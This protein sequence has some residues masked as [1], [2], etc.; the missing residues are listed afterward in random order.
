MLLLNV[1]SDI[2]HYVSFWYLDL[3]LSEELIYLRSFETSLK[4]FVLSHTEFSICDSL[5]ELFDCSTD[6]SD[7]SLSDDVEELLDLTVQYSIDDFLN[8]CTQLS[9][10]QSVD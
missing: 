6:K 7:V 1:N 9:Y 5:Q 8:A 4:Y 2:L 3:S 10:N